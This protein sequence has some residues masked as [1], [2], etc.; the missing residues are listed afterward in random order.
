MKKLLISMFIIGGSLYSFS[1]NQSW[2]LA[3]DYIEIGGLGQQPLP[4]TTGGY[5][6]QPATGAQNMIT[7]ASGQIIFF[8]VDEYIYGRNGEIIDR[9]ELYSGEPIAGVNSEI[10]I[11]KDPSDCNI[12]HLLSTQDI[13][14]N[15]KISEAYYAKLRVSYNSQ[16]QLNAN[17]G[18]YYTDIEDCSSY[19]QKIETM[20]GST[21]YSS[22]GGGG[23]PH[24]ENALFAVAPPSSNGVQKVYVTN[25]KRIFPFT[26]SSNSFTYDGDYI[27]LE[28]DVYTS[29]EVG[30]PTSDRREFEVVKL[31]NGNYRLG[32]FLEYL[33]P[34]VAG[35][36]SSVGTIDVNSNGT[37]I[38]GS[39]KRCEYETSG[40]IGANDYIALITGIEF[41]PYGD[42][43]FIT[44]KQ[45][46]PSGNSTLDYWDLTT[47]TPTRTALSTNLE[48]QTGQIE[49]A[50]DGSLMLPRQNYLA[51]I[52]T[53]NGTPAINE[54]AVPIASYNHTINADRNFV[55]LLQDQVD[56]E[57]Y[58]NLSPTMYNA[59]VYNVTTSGTWT[60]NTIAS[61]Y[62]NNPLIYGFGNIVNIEKELR[63]KAGVTLTIENMTFQ[64]SPG[65]RVV[66]EHGING[67]QGGKL[68]LKNSTFTN[69]PGCNSNEQWLGVEVWGNQVLTQGNINSSSQGRLIL[70]N[71]QIENASIGVLVSKRQST[72]GGIPIYNTF[73]VTNTSNQDLEI[74]QP[75]TFDNAR[76][77]GIVQATNS[78]FLNNQRGVWFRPYGLANGANNLSYFYTSDFIWN[79]NILTSVQD[80]A[81][82]ETV[83]GV[84]FKGCNFQ[85]DIAAGSS[86][87]NGYG[88][89]SRESQF[90]ATPYC[91]AIILNQPC[92]AS[93]PNTFKN[94]NFGIRA[95]NTNAWS[96][97][98]NENVFIDNRYGVYVIGTQA[99]RILKNDFAI[100]EANYQTAGISLYNSSGYFVQ[101]NELYEFDNPLIANGTGNSYG[102]VVSN[103]GIATNEIYKNYFHNLKIGGQTERINAPLVPDPTNAEIQG[104][105]WLCNDFQHD[106]YEHDMTL[107]FGR[108]DYHQGAAT[109]GTTTLEA[110]RKAAN[111]LFSLTGENFLDFHDIYSESSEPF[112]YAHIDAPRHKPDSYSAANN[113]YLNA[114]GL[115]QVLV[116]NPPLPIL[117]DA[118]TCPSKIKKVVGFVSSFPVILGLKEEVSHLLNQIDDSRT[119][120][121]LTLIDNG[122][123][124]EVKNALLDASPYLSDEVLIAYV[125]SSPP[126]GNLMEV[127]NANSNLSNAVKAVLVNHA[128]PNGTANQIAATQ[129][130]ISERTQ[131]FA[132]ASY[133]NRQAELEYADLISQTLLDDSDTA[134]L[135]SL[136]AILEYAGDYERIKLLLSTYVTIN[137]EVRANEQRQV[138][139]NMNP[140]P[141]FLELTEIQEEITSDEV[142]GEVILSDSVLETRVANLV[143]NSTDENIAAKAQCLL[144][145]RYNNDQVPEFISVALVKSNNSNAAQS[146][147][148]DLHRNFNVSI[149]PNPTTGIVNFD[150]PDNTSGTLEIQIISLDGKVKAEFIVEDTNGEQFNL[151]YLDKGCY[152]V[153]ITLDGQILETQK[154]E[155]F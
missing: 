84:N 103:S 119:G 108:M 67:Q 117:S 100:R 78:T 59:F 50:V 127:M 54:T 15:I 89:N 8:I 99:E 2:I 88:I 57:D 18:F 133:I 48:F 122:S 79:D 80:L 145:Y 114:I 110:A 20:I 5:Q 16:G 109:G 97:I 13:S 23:N 98:C 60:P 146:E 65:A 71:S 153:K 125:N 1:Q 32:F 61:S 17:S 11:V 151:D 19:L 150:Y 154:L 138:L 63:I 68:I 147:N 64:F 126:N 94:L 131:L 129:I 135:V 6:N 121:L 77:G 69:N 115:D 87:Q 141:Y 134:S 93:L 14:P 28:F 142:A 45:Y 72:L 51:K 113:L 22:N 21:Y 118:G 4:T 85:N 66:I 31:Q 81:R 70:T 53:P 47:A 106:I 44:H 36:K 92:P 86:F 120:E 46:G 30:S 38:N 139:S 41:S 137:D 10:V 91:G 56:G 104:L 33:I 24:D 3:P 25:G 29:L 34:G 149:Y 27:D 75:F 82:L 101:E 116:G 95:T 49:A 83:K 155:L 102:I 52:S 140:C 42:K 9:F 73:C 12:F 62:N 74:I 132:E 58:S 148:I 130:G 144:D 7:D 124:G 40:F 152:L 26:L 96:F 90:Y 111:N 39:Q 55:R 136:I 35:Y 105:Q 128:M 43:V 107:M 112:T 76:D 143:Q 37:F 123:N